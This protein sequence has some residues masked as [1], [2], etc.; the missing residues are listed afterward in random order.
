M[1]RLSQRAAGADVPA[2]RG[3]G[4]GVLDLETW[5]IE[6]LGYSPD[7]GWMPILHREIRAGNIPFPEYDGKGKP[8]DV[9]AGESW[10]VR[11]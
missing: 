3:S 1:A 6:R 9:Q 2:R 5:Y 11:G 4:D 8:G 10:P 7:D